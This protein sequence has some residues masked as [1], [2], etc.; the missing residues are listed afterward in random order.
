MAI[1]NFS[2]IYRHG[3]I[4][5]LHVNRPQK[6]SKPTILIVRNIFARKKLS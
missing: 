6:H 4:L 5:R 1:E 2:N 3:N